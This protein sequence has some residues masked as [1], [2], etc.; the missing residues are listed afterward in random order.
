MSS[1]DECTYPGVANE[2]RTEM[3]PV[4]DAAT[5]ELLTPSFGQA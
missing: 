2:D 3:A 1:P 4:A 5:L